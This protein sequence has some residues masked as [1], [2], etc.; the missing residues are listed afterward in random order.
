VVMLFT[1]FCL[2]P[3]TIPASA[4]VPVVVVP[5]AKFRRLVGQPRQR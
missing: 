1:T 3:F 4:F 2:I 5:V